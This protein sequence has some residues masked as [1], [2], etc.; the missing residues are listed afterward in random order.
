MT[1]NKA[2]RAEREDMM[3]SKIPT[4]SFADLNLNDIPSESPVRRTVRSATVL[5]TATCL[6]FAIGGPWS[7]LR[8]RGHNGNARYIAR[9]DGASV[10]M[11]DK[12]P[13]YQEHTSERLYF[14]SRAIV[15]FQ[16]APDPINAMEIVYRAD[17]RIPEPR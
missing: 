2:S 6:G 3:S 9:G 16:T 17:Q 8:R 4:T 7:E 1:R 5:T 10:W 11:Y 14:E 12:L 15:E 13:D